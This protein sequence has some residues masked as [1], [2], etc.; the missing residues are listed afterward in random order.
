M[1]IYIA[2]TSYSTKKK[3]KK[4]ASTTFFNLRVKFGHLISP[5]TFLTLNG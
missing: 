2:L 3:K 1:Y 5:E 4:N